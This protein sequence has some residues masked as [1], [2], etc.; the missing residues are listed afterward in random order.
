MNV[1]VSFGSR[2]RS[3]TQFGVQPGSMK[4]VPWLVTIVSVLRMSVAM[5]ADV[6]VDTSIAKVTAYQQGAM[7]TRTGDAPISVGTQRLS[8]TG[9]PANLDTS[10]IRV[11]VNSKAVKL[12]SVSTEVITQADYIATQERQLRK[13]I[14]KLEDEKVALYDAIGVAESQMRVLDT[15]AFGQPKEG[16]KSSIDVQSLQG[17]ISVMATTGSDARSKIRDSKIRIREIDRSIAKLNED[18]RKV[19]TARKSSLSVFALVNASSAVTAPVSLTYVVRDSK[20][21]W[22]YEAHLDTA[23]KQVDFMKLA[24]LEQGSGEDWSNVELTL[25]ASL[26]AQ[27]NALAPLRSLLLRSE[28]IGI[29]RSSGSVGGDNFDISEVVVTGHRVGARPPRRERTT[30][31]E[32]DL[33]T[34]V[35]MDAN[36]T[37]FVTDYLVPGKISVTSNREPRTFPVNEDSFAVELIARTIP[38]R[39]RQAYV[40]ATFKYDRDT[41]MQSA[42]L[43]LFRDDAYIGKAQLDTF[44]PGA[45]VRLPFGVDERIRVSVKQEK[46]QSGKRGLTGR[47]KVRDERLRFEIANFHSYP[48]KVE[49]LDRVPIPKSNDVHIEIP[50]GST[51]PTKRDYEE[52]PGLLLWALNIEPRQTAAI[53][54]YVEIRY[55]ADKQLAG[56]EAND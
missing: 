2:L 46:E 35:E 44:L 55:P 21:K 3:A 1:T 28:D 36:V 38:R 52:K 23:A 8:I 9:L 49:V 34:Y 18:L 54:H 37:E 14:E 16:A 20:W 7:V 50:N 43:Q 17:V 26:P 13:E 31:S 42:E 6:S 47:Q 56:F 27:N 11:V 12:G 4:V 19:G 30:S 32:P 45:D 24:Q 10:L 5:S 15:T 51:P 22:I 39:E 25:T 53:R 33:G 40:E 41:P 48:I 29:R